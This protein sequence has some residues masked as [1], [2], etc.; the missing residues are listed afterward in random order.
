MR[1]YSRITSS[2]GCKFRSGS[3][4]GYA[5]CILMQAY[6][7]LHGT[8]PTFLADSLR[9]TA[10]VDGRRRLRSSV[11]DTLVVAPT[12][13]STLG[14]RAHPV[15][16]SRARNGLPSSVTAAS[17]LSMFRQELTEDLSL[18]VEFS[19][20]YLGRSLTGTVFSASVAYLLTL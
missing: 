18:P 19:V 5:F 7:C 1:L 12:N 6:R 14:D 20:T 16:A 2:S 17:S 15:A 10:D 13:R 8:S 11:S 3:G 4:L 9:R